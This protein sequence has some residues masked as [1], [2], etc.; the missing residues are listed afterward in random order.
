MVVR[1]HK[2]II[3]LVLVLLQVT[4]VN[5]KYP[6]LFCFVLNRKGSIAD[7]WDSQTSSWSLYFR[8]LLKDE[9]VPDSQALL[10]S[11]EGIM[12][13]SLNRR[14]WSLGSGGS[15]TIKSLVNHL[16]TASPIDITILSFWKSKSPKRVNISVWIMLHGSLNC[17]SILQKKLPSHCLSPHMC[18]LYLNHQENL[19]H[20]FFDCFY[21]AKCWNQLL[22]TFNLCWAFDDNIRINML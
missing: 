21:A 14:I 1:K 7:Q 4:K 13:N 18:P 6:S 3:T 17:A 12:I 20:L 16:S 15:F 2:K 5:S 9:E 22:Q 19:Q 8:R 10:S 11:L